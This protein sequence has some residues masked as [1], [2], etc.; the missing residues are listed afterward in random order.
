[1]QQLEMESEGSNERM[2]LL[3]LPREILAPTQSNHDKDPSSTYNSYRYVIFLK[4][5]ARDEEL[6]C[7]LHR[8]SGST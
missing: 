7:F 2:W 3:L 8:D 5:F 4:K 6:P 1:M